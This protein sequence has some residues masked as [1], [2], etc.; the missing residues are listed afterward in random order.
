MKSSDTLK[1][2]DAEPVSA[3]NLKVPAPARERE[4]IEAEGDNERDKE[5]VSRVN[6]F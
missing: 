1:D 6:H 2:T 5:T 3:P 4:S